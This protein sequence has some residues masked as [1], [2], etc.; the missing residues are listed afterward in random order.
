MLDTN[1]LSAIM[2]AKPDPVVAAW[3][4]ARRADQLFTTTICQAEI[5]AGIAVVP[6]GRRSSALAAAAEAIFAHD[7][8]DRVLTFDAASAVAYAEIFAARRRAGRSAPTLDLMIAAIARAR[9]AG[10]VTGNADDFAGCG[11]DVVDPWH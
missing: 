11:I 7:F 2:R 8:G 5:L 4:A 3:I 9:G 6:G 10:V 1:V